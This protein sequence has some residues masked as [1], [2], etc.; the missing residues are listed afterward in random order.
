MKKR[1]NESKKIGICFICGK[2]DVVVTDDN[3]PPKNIFVKPRPINTITIEACEIC[4]SGSSDSDQKFG[5]FLSLH[6]AESHEKADLL[7]RTKTM[8][9][10]ERTL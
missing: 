4:N 10:A 7:L 8:N 3:V 2:T 5:V 1:K 6:A 9:K